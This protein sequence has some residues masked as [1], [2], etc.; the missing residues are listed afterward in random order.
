MRVD[1]ADVDLVAV[2]GNAAVRRMQLL[3]RRRQLAGVAP[4]EV[5]RRRV[6]G[7]DLVLGRRD[8][9]APVVDDGR[10]L[11]PLADTGCENVQTGFRRPTLAV[12]IWSSGLYPQPSYVRRYMSQLPGSGFCRRSVVTGV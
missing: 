5:P 3:Q 10:R 8:E 6:E 4:E 12:V 1:G 9:H 7:E 2:Q 11:V